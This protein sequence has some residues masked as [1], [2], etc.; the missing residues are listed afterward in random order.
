[1]DG[2]GSIAMTGRRGFLGLF[3][4]AVAA[5]VVAVKVEPVAKVPP[6]SAPP[7][8][9]KFAMPPMPEYLRYMQPDPMCVTTS[10]SVSFMIPATFGPVS[11]NSGQ[12]YV[13]GQQMRELNRGAR[14]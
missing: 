3:S 12:L 2:D 14:S 13:V 4:G 6:V 8:T 5:G 11:F 1:M 7:V 10:C 9:E